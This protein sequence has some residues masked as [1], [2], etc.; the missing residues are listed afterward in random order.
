MEVDLT[1]WKLEDAK[2]RFSE[3]V[4]R[5][6]S[7][8][9]QL[10]TRHGKEAAVVLGVEEYRQL[11]QPVDLVE[12]LTGSPLAVALEAGELTLDRPREFGRDLSL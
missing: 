3:L 8:G 9:P 4:R 10:V 12:F 7:E 5:A 2:N 1:A 6:A 11:T